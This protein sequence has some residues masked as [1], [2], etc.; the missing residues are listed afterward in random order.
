MGRDRR[1]RHA[2]APPVVARKSPEVSLGK[3]GCYVTRT[4]AV[5][6]T[7]RTD[8]A[9]HKGKKAIPKCLHSYPDAPNLVEGK[10]SKVD[11]HNLA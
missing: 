7:S 8:D 2:A 3:E 9:R 6:P 1:G 4:A 5:G 11:I 10:F